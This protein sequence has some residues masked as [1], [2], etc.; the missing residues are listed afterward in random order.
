MGYLCKVYLCNQKSL[1]D[2]GYCEGHPPKFK[3]VTLLQSKPHIPKSQQ[4]YNSLARREWGRHGFIK[5]RYRK[6]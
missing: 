2:T 4:E 3:A 6:K 5:L 1:G